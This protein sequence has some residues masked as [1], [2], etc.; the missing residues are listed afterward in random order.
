MSV[1]LSLQ[2]IEASEQDNMPHPNEG[3]INI[4]KVQKKSGK[5]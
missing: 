3:C 2:G 1:T 5:A 4:R